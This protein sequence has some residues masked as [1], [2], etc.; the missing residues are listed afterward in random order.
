MPTLLLLCL[1]L[2]AV[3]VTAAVPKPT[4]FGYGCPL[5]LVDETGLYTLTL[6]LTVYERVTRAD[7]G[8]LR[9]F[10]GA[11]E[12]VPHALRRPPQPTDQPQ[13]RQA[14]PFFALPSGPP[15]QTGDLALQ[16]SR[17]TNGTVIRVESGQAG[18]QPGPTGYL[19]DTSALQPSPAALELTWAGDRS[20]VFTLSLAHS[21]DLSHW[22]PLVDRAVLA[23]LNA[24][25]KNLTLRRITLPT[26]P[27]P[28]IRLD[29][30]DC[31]VPL[32]LQ[33]VTALSTIPAPA[34]QWQWLRLTPETIETDK[35]EQVVVYNLKARVAVTALQLRFS[36]ANS[37]VKA[38][39]ESRPS[40]D[41]AWQPRA[42]STFFRLN[43]E[44]KE[45][46]G[47]PALCGPTSDGQWRLRLDPDSGLSDAPQ[48]PQLELGWQA[49][50]LVF[51]GRGPGPYT[52]AFGSARPVTTRTDDLLLTAIGTTGDPLARR[53]EP[54]PV[55]TLG[56][57][58][59]LQA[60]RPALPWQ[61]ILLWAIL[62]AGVGLLAA[63][64]RTILREIQANKG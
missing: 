62:I 14:I 17:H 2:V 21:S 34:E 20:S 57:E 3:P 53:I 28:Y 15:S 49:E 11:G 52:L 39:I 12:P 58:Q 8:D 4:D 27:L 19:L 40:S 18:L 33:A 50:E 44:G 31:R 29:C 23:D 60:D 5:P 36:Q 64:A 46:K 51:V 13:V 6:P 59:A 37:L 47:D 16:V 38:T 24:Q 54:G 42:R 30:L 7:L 26:K 1:L 63:M 35:G 32:D 9:V 48:A 10:N 61:R 55:T 43:L 41:L 45:R 22:S 25:G 56:G